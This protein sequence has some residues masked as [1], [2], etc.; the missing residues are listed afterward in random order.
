VRTSRLHSG[1][2]SGDLAT[3]SKALAELDAS[4]SVVRRRIRGVLGQVP[5]EDHA[6]AARA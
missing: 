2:W 1:T 3:V 5:S 4:L 6:D